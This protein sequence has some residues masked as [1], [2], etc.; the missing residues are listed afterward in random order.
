M[1]RAKNLGVHLQ[2]MMQV[3]SFIFGI[4]GLSLFVLAFIFPST[5]TKASY[6]GGEW[7]SNA[8]IKGGVGSCAELAYAL[9]YVVDHGDAEAAETFGAASVDKAEA[10][11]VVDGYVTSSN[12][13]YIN[14]DKLVAKDAFTFGR[15]HIYGSTAMLNGAWK[16]PP[17][18]SFRSE[19]I[20]AF[21][22]MVNGRF[23][24]AV[25]KTCGNPVMAT[26]I[27]PPPTK[28]APSPNTN[29]VKKV[30]TNLSAN[31]D[32]AYFYGQENVSAEQGQVVR[33]VSQA[34][35]TGN[36]AEKIVVSDTLP[37][38]TTYVSGTFQQKRAGRIIL[39][40]AL[41]PI[42]STTYGTVR[43]TLPGD[44]VKIDI[45]ATFN[46]SKKVR[47]IA[48]VAIDVNKD[49]LGDG[50]PKC[51]DAYVTPL[52][53]PSASCVSLTAKQ[54]ANNKY[55]FDV[56]ASA[57]NG[58]RINGFVIDFGDGTSK[59][60]NVSGATTAN[61]THQYAALD[62]TMTAV[63]TAKT[64]AGD[65]TSNACKA[66]VTTT[67]PSVACIKLSSNTI[68]RTTREF[69]VQS[70][71][72]NGGKITK[73]VFDL[74]DNETID[75]TL[76][77]TRI[78]FRN[79]GRYTVKVILKT[80]VGDVTSP[81]CEVTVNISEEDEP[82]IDIEKKVTADLN[83]P[84]NEAGFSGTQELV[85]VAPNQE[86]RFIIKLTNTGNVALKDVKVH[87]QLP[88]GLDFVSGDQDAVIPSLEP[89]AVRYFAVNARASA[90]VG[91]TTVTNVVCTAH[92][93][94]E[95]GEVDLNCTK[96]D[97]PMNPDIKPG[98]DL[99]DCDDANVKIVPTIS[100]PQSGPP[101]S[102]PRTGPISSAIA[103]LAMIGFSARSWLLSR[104][105]L[106]SA[107]LNKHN[108]TSHH[109]LG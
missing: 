97:C 15:D 34:N 58:A 20:P 37:A 18:V 69:S 53:T 47:N 24:W 56:R 101:G 87:D 71:V 23:Q 22:Y 52:P 85:E 76:P 31:T 89:G 70:K 94:D 104:R 29:I 83:A 28:P 61:F 4:V 81:A 25:I 8:I 63:V 88:E 5:Q 42:N 1:K 75:S 90:T 64:S 107:H 105:Q 6:P 106:L 84:A 7:D 74:G 95:D 72:T 14:G 55:S 65:K 2:H 60:V 40:G 48:C 39:T 46:S 10:C 79:P 99:H 33:F 93:T 73:Y 11:N 32:E 51:D 109:H 54:I 82:S 21:V 35:N 9:Q 62:K 66:P 98:D 50:Y 80:N 19:S 57:I 12:N 108:N 44:E 77:R 16:R 41:G 43:D 38:G 27:A 96:E 68:N 59:T 100:P 49:G 86:V 17:S 3:R 26:A 103:G 92:D 13:V 30:S 78:N 102:L 91:A 45:R 36:T 67:K